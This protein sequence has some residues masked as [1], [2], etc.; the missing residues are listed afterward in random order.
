M[1]S[2][3]NKYKNQLEHRS[4]NKLMA[5]IYLVLYLLLIKYTVTIFMRILCLTCLQMSRQWYYY[6]NVFT[7]KTVISSD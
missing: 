1:F 4:L 5:F 2:N 6:Y 7:V 3:F